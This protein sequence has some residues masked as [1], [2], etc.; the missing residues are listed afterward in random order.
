MTIIDPCDA[1]VSL[2]PSTLTDQEYTITQNEDSYQ[3][4][5]FDA[6]PIWCDITYSYS[7]SDPSGDKAIISF[8][9]ATQTFSF[10]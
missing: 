7:V 1:P 6:D 5:A 10:F 2:V 4:P 3:V 9:A 8:D